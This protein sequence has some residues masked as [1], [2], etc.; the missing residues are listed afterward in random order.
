[1]TQNR[2]TA[3]MQRR[4]EAH[5][6]LDDFPTPPWA[7]RA[8]CEFLEARGQQLANMSVREPCANRGYMV[9]PLLESFG[10]VLASDIHD[11]GF[12]FPVQDYLFGPDD[13]QSHTDWTFMN[14]PF[15]LAAQFIQKALRL[16]RVG[17]AAVVRTAFLEG[18]ERYETLFSQCPPWAVAV[19]VE[20]VPM[21]KGRVDPDAASATSYT[22][23]FWRTDT[24]ERLPLDWIPRCRKR[25]ERA[26]DYE[27]AS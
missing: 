11:Y 10:M 25:L 12:G 23:I 6:S 1:M 14:P 8:A 13:W 7:T 17:V 9:R 27:V 26:S 2:S 18:N 19:H 15:R 3:V 5:D 16:S 20:R 24:D 4:V 22:W 21:V